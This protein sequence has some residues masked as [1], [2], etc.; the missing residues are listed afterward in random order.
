VV[1]QSIGY[2]SRQVVWQRGQLDDDDRTVSFRGKRVNE[3][4]EHSHYKLLTQNGA[5]RTA[6]AR[7]TIALSDSGM[8]ISINSERSEK[9]AWS[10]LGLLAEHFIGNEAACLRGTEA[11][12]GQQFCGNT[13]EWQDEDDAWVAEIDALKPLTMYQIAFTAF[14]DGLELYADGNNRLFDPANQLRVRG[15]LTA[16]KRYQFNVM[17]G[18][19]SNKLFFGLPA[20]GYSGDVSDLM[21]IAAVNEILPERSIG[22][23]DWEPHG[24][25]HTF[26]IE[27]LLQD[28]EYMG[29]VTVHDNC[30]R[31]EQ[32]AGGANGNMLGN[33][34]AEGVARFPIMT[35]GNGDAML[36]LSGCA[37]PEKMISAV[38]VYQEQ[39]PKP[40]VEVE[41]DVWLSLSRESFWVRVSGVLPDWPVEGQMAIKNNCAK[42]VNANNPSNPETLIDNVDVGTHDFTTTADTDGSI[43]FELSNCPFSNDLQVEDVIGSIFLR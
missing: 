37:E 38:N 16:V 2:K 10:Q 43:R 4:S 25:A 12:D 3:S 32:Q 9:N 7:D 27:G 36:A 40:V 22:S 33:T 14:D 35:D 26:P 1:T 30:A 18:A 29:V 34:D 41:T 31:L 15:G 24:T 23:D 21:S 28:Q 17:T 13:W 19:D 20:Q 42:L 8:M 6:G 11:F 5:R 39:A